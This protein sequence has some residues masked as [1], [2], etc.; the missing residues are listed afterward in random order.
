MKLLTAKKW[1]VV[2]AAG[3]LIFS[4]GVSLA[5]APSAQAV[6]YPNSTGVP[7]DRD[8]IKITNL[9]GAEI[10]TLTRGDSFRLTAAWE[11]MSQDKN[12]NIYIYNLDTGEGVR[13]ATATISSIVIDDQPMLYVQ[14]TFNNLGSTAVPLGAIDGGDCRIV[15]YQKAENSTWASVKGLILSD[16]SYFKDNGQLPLHS[17]VEAFIDVKL[18]LGTITLS[19]TSG[20][21]ASNISVSGTTLAPGNIREAYWESTSSTS[22][23]RVSISVVGWTVNASGNLSA[24]FAV[25][26]CPRGTY[27]LSILDS[28]NRTTKSANYSVNPKGTVSTAS[29]TAG[30]SVTVS[31][32]G[33]ASNENISVRLT[34]NSVVTILAPSSVTVDAYGNFSGTFVVPITL[35]AG[36]YSLSIVGPT[37][38]TITVGNIA[39][40]QITLTLTNATTSLNHV[41]FGY[42]G[43]ISL[44]ASGLVPGQ[45]YWLK[46]GVLVDSAN[47]FLS[48]TIVLGSAV[49]KNDGT[50]EVTYE[51]SDT[52]KN[53]K[54]TYRIGITESES[55]V[56]PRAKAEKSVSFKF[57]SPA[58]NPSLVSPKPGA[59]AGTAPS[60]TWSIVANVP[61]LYYVISIATDEALSS[62]IFTQKVDN[63]NSFSLPEGQLEKGTYYWTVQAFDGFGTASAATK[64]VSPFKVGGAG[65][66][67]GGDN[68]VIWI[69]VGVVI[70]LALVVIIYILMRRRTVY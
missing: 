70:L 7:G 2:L 6:R 48:G 10:S 29:V 36:T 46:M 16:M 53:M 17:Y 45:T 58:A 68:L 20:N 4:L 61:G 49:A 64:E 60:F 44:F 47:E 43:T 69:A 37:S 11:I 12:Y 55:S 28:D 63:G 1:W 35:A 42:G 3:L 22:F 59:N 34:L 9:S 50:I 57:V 14:N 24:T 65:I 31:G 33:F 67:F 27:V 62:I 13:W 56:Q 38:G 52:F 21:V 19:P 30:N 40:T 39:V 32:N 26:N 15:Y 54:E 5:L 18:S 23:E 51:V 8:F 25:P 66:N 41:E